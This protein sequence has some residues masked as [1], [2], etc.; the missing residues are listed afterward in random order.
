MPLSLPFLYHLLVSVTGVWVSECLGL[1]QEWSREC[2]AQLMHYGTAVRGHL[3]H[4]LLPLQ[5]CTVPNWWSP[6]A[7]SLSETPVAKL[8]VVSG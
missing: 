3:D 5:V 4:G 1:F 2:Y 8:V 6:Q 7:S